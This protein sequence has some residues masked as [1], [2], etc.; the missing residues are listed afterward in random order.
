MFGVALGKLGN[1]AQQPVAL[2][3]K[4]TLNRLE[5]A[6]HIEGNTAWPI[7]TWLRPNVVRFDSNC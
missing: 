7:Q 5:Q 1:E 2:A 3:G 4:S 6:M